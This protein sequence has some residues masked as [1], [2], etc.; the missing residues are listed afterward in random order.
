LLVQ[1]LEVAAFYPDRAL[2]GFGDV[3]LLVED[4]AKARASLLDT[5]FEP[6]EPGETSALRWDE[7]TVPVELFD[8]PRWL[9][10]LAAPP[11]HRLLSLAQ[12]SST[13]IHGVGALPAPYHALVVATNAWAHKPLRRARDLVDIAALTAGIDGRLMESAA[14]EWGLDRLWRTTSRAADALLSPSVRPSLGLRLLAAD[15]WELREERWPERIARRY[16]ASF[17]ALAAPAALRTGLATFARDV[18]GRPGESL[19]AKLRRIR[20]GL[21][22][23]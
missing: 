9:P 10:E 15:V 1:G 23:A 8:S 6:V 2:R 20:C 19:R 14:C 5:G 16:A 7:A 13:G 11:L 17:F 4:A 3:D 21:T 18:R 22:S 12:P